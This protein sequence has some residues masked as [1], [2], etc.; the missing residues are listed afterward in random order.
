VEIAG[1]GIHVL[2]GVLEHERT[3]L[4][5]ATRALDAIVSHES[6]ARIAPPAV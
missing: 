5:A 1:R 6:A 4:C 3:L 2:P